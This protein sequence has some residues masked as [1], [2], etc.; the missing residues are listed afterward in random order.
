ME[1]FKIII[2]TKK[3]IIT[4]AEIQ[5]KKNFLKPWGLFIENLPIIKSIK[6]L[7]IYVVNIPGITNVL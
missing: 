7:K 6:K 5:I 3:P 4:S 2:N 1:G